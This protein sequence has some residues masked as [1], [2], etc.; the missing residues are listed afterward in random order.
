M[1]VKSF[2]SFFFWEACVRKLTI[3]HLLQ[4]PKWPG[5]APSPHDYKDFFFQLWIYDLQIG[6]DLAGSNLIPRAFDEKVM[7]QSPELDFVCDD[8]L[9]NFAYDGDKTQWKVYEPIT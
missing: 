9:K 6:R 4:L 8:L 5:K 2:L 3:T 1:N 7:M